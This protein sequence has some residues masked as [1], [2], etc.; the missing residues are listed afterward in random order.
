MPST[1]APSL[2]FSFGKRTVLFPISFALV[3]IGRIPFTGLT[4][5]SSPSSPKITVSLTLNSST[6]PIAKSI[7]IAMGRSITMPSFLISAGERLTVIL[8]AGIF[9]P[10]FLSATLT[11]SPASLTS[12]L[13]KP[14]ILKPGSP[15]ETST[16]TSIR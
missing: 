15:V 8:E 3:T 9:T 1:T 11:L 2:A 10:M 16:S 12:P 14:T 6:S 5:P 7:A 13:I 4:A